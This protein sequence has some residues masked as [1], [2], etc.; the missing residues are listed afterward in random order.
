ECRVRADEAKR[1][2]SSCLSTVVGAA[3]MG[4]R[5]EVARSRTL[6]AYY[7]SVYRRYDRV[8]RY[9]WESLSPEVAPAYPAVE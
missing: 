3:R 5:A 7:D 9:P 1:A 8:A 6:A 4:D 2:C